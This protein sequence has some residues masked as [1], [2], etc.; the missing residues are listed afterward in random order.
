[1]FGKEYKVN[2]E[3]LVQRIG[4]YATII[5]DGKI[6]LTKQRK[7]YS[8]IGGGVDK[9]E[10]LEEAI[11]REVKEETGLD[12]KPGEIFYQTTKF[13]QKNTESKPHQSF[14]FY[15]LGKVSGEISNSSITD[16]EHSYTDDAP[17]WVDLKQAK[18]IDLRHS[19]DLKTLLTEYNGQHR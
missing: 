18:K 12:F 7:G 6:L 13:F 19:V 15:F 8:L 9:G 4:V 17:E 11:V 16:S 3:D 14:Q 1:V 5:Q 2:A 10:T